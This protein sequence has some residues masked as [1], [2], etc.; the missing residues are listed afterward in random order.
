[1]D[2]IQK[3]SSDVQRIRHASFQ[4]SAGETCQALCALLEQSHPAIRELAVS[5]G[6]YWLSCVDA[7][8][9]GAPSEREI[10]KLCALHALLLGEADFTTALSKKDW[11][12]LC[13]LTSYEAESLPL[14]VL[15]MLMSLFVEKQAL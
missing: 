9:T 2:A 13:A 11:K 15:N 10:E 12:E 5:F 14:D 8:A 6:Q 7:S 3:F 4:R 1:M